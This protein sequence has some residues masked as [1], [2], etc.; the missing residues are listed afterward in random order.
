MSLHMEELD[1]AYFEQRSTT[2]ALYRPSPGTHQIR[3]A[4][5]R[6]S[7]VL[8]QH[9]AVQPPVTNLH[10]SDQFRIA[11]STV[12]STQPTMGRNPMCRQ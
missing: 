8:P 12:L 1:K 11:R 4:R 9:W 3:T 5:I 7:T 6:H 10:V 2:V